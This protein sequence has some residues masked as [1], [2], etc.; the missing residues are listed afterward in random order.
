M[1][2]C[3]SL[4]AKSTNIQVT[5][6][7]GGLKLIQIQDNGTGIRVS[8]RGKDPP[9][10]QCLHQT[11]WQHFKIHLFH[12]HSFSADI[13]HLPNYQYRLSQ[14]SDPIFVFL[15]PKPKIL[16]KDIDCFRCR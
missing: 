4:D 9:L 13:Q 2:I 11:K 12:L 10:L 7:D 6:K 15:C 5:V 14:K 1:I 16:M 3:C 8:D